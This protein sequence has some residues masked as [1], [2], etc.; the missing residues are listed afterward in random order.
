MSFFD[1]VQVKELEQSD[2]LIGDVLQLSSV[3][4]DKVAE[5]IRL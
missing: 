2:F 3:K 4:F 5:M 1:K